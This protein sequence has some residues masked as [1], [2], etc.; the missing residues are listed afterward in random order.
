LENLSKKREKFAKA[1]VEEP[2]DTKVF[3]LNFAKVEDVEK[4]IKGMVSGRG[5]M[6]S[7]S[8][9]NILVVTDTQS[10][11]KMLEDSI[12]AMDMITPQVRIVAK[13]VEADANLV[14]NIGVNW[15]LSGSVSG[16]KRPISWPFASVTSTAKSKFT[17]DSFPAAPATANAAGSLFSFGVLD[18]SSLSAALEIILNDGNTEIKSEPQITTLDNQT[19]TIEVVTKDPLPNYTYNSQTG[20]WEISG[21]N[22]IEYGV[23]LEVTPQINKEKFITLLVKP[24]VSELSGEK[25]FTSGGSGSSIQ[26]PILDTQTTTTKVMVKDGATLVIA[27]LIRD[28]VITSTNKV[29]ILG[30]I[31]V[32]DYLFK[33]KSKSVE[34]KNLMI[35]ITPEIVTPEMNVPEVKKETAK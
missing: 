26:V 1:K 13:I 30:D 20:S 2:T 4:K 23:T 22:W 35:F 24:T 16:S 31:W 3:T 12:K 11:L 7:D 18:A 27:G 29:P 15:N 5:K 19:A 9:T 8:R 21:Y 14:N 28:K 32:L 10:N 25:T 33:H 34:K 6:I 17:A